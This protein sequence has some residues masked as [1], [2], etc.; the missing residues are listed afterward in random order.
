MIQTWIRDFDGQLSNIHK[1][2]QECDIYTTSLT[3]PSLLWYNTKIFSPISIPPSS[4]PLKIE[5]LSELF[6]DG[7]K[8]NIIKKPIH[9][10]GRNRFQS[11]SCVEKRARSNSS[12]SGYF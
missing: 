4:P 2:S 10:K 7:E 5:I 1:L 12:T 11:I 3:Q 8:K 6:S 9:K